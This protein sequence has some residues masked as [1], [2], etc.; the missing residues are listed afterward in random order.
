MVSLMGLLMSGCPKIWICSQ[1]SL[2]LPRR[3]YSPLLENEG[4]KL[5]SR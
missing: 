5:M 2:A 3:S 1:V 4:V